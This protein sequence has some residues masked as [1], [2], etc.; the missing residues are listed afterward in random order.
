MLILWCLAILPMNLLEKKKKV[1]FL[2]F[3][4]FLVS[5]TL[6]SWNLHLNAIGDVH[7]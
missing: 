6:L 1:C 5:L 3:V 2:T 4:L 7:V